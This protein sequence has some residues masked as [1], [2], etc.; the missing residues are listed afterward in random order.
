MSKRRDRYGNE[1]SYY[2]NRGVCKEPT[3]LHSGLVVLHAAAHFGWR[4]WISDF[5][6]TTM[7]S[8]LLV[9]N[10]LNA[11]S[12]LHRGHSRGQRASEGGCVLLL[13]SNIRHWGML[14]N[15]NMSS[16]ALTMITCTQRHLPPFFLRLWGFIFHLI[17][18]TTASVRQRWSSSC[19]W[20]RTAGF[21]VLVKRPLTEAKM[22]HVLLPSQFNRDTPTAHWDML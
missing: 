10:N 5:R 11:W 20:W 6:R 12:A 9:R 16:P 3:T 1:I 13:C 22:K 15:T 8:V 18:L 19:T 21:G 7:M 17:G 4:T 2:R 14:L